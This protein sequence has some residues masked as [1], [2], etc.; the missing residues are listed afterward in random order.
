MGA[1]A[2]DPPDEDWLGQPAP[3]VELKAVSTEDG[4]LFVEP[5]EEARM[6]G[7][8]HNERWPERESLTNV[9]AEVRPF[10]NFS[11]RGN[12][13]LWRSVALGQVAQST[14]DVT[15]SSDSPAAFE[16]GQDLESIVDIHTDQGFARATPVVPTGEPGPPARW[17]G[18]GVHEIAPGVESM[19]VPITPTGSGRIRDL[20]AHLNVDHPALGDLAIWLY[21]PSWRSSTLLFRD[22][23]P[24]PGASNLTFDDEAPPENGYSGAISPSETALS[25][26]L[27]APE[28]W[29]FEGDR[30]EGTWELLVSNFGS[31]PGRLSWDATSSQAVCRDSRSQPAADYQRSL[32]PSTRQFSMRVPRRF[33]I[34]DANR[35]GIP[36][37]VKCKRVCAVDAELQITRRQARRLGLKGPRTRKLTVAASARARPKSRHRFLLRPNARVRRALRRARKVPVLV[38]VTSGGRTAQAKVE[39]TRR[40]RR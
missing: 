28:M 2:A 27:H 19:R 10:S 17:G 33:R 23:G 7:I 6:R 36:V 22:G 5:G 18:S 14:N 39:L 4:D 11:V 9:R 3:W 24:T 30:L 16:C 15:L 21:S 40:K 13:L 20:D 37:T 25:G 1:A 29:V 32:A 12:P 26:R 38:R 8:M 34:A 35:K 31:H